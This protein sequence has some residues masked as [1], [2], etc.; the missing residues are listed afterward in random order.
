M[1]WGHPNFGLLVFLFF[2][3]SISHSSIIRTREKTFSSD[4]NPGFTRVSHC[5]RP[6]ISCASTI[7]FAVSRM[8]AASPNLVESRSQ[9][10]LSQ[11]PTR[12]LSRL[13]H[14]KSSRNCIIAGG[15]STRRSSRW[16][17]PLSGVRIF[18][19]LQFVVRCPDKGLLCQRLVPWTMIFRCWLENC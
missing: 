14:R 3:F 15:R 12:Q 1:A 17:G 9:F 8:Y 11:C 18:F 6:C 7:R 16:W 5:F 13:T 10:R 19:R 4:Q 2:F